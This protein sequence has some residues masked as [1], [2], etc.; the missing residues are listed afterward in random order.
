[1]GEVAKP[2]QAS[3]D[4]VMDLPDESGIWPAFDD[5]SKTPNY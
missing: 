4:P 1:M 3:I 2:F 5:L